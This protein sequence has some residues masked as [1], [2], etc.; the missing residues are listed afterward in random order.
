[1][2][3][4]CFILLLLSFIH[5]CIPSYIDRTKVE[6]RFKRSPAEVTVH[7]KSLYVLAGGNLAS[8]AIA[9]NIFLALESKM[10]QNNSKAEFKFINTEQDYTKEVDIK[11][12]LSDSFD[13]YMLLSSNDSKWVDFSTQK[14]VFG[15]PV[16][17]GYW[18]Q[19]SG[20]GDSYDGD[21]RVELYNSNKK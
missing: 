13:G 14:F 3:R 1:M 5:S 4:I 2:K 8:R 12:I 9:D 7:V 16:S 20:Y 18:A 15:A 19:G 11:S 17:P 21:I 10:N 6:T